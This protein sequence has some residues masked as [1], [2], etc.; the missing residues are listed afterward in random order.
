MKI[1]YIAQSYNKVKN[2]GVKPSTDFEDVLSSLG[3]KNIGLKR[4]YTPQRYISRMINAISTA[5]ALYVMPNKG[6]VFLQYPMQYN[7]EKL[8]KKA[9][10]NNNK[11]ILLVHDLNELRGKEYNYPSI[12]RE[13]DA[14]IVHTKPMRQLIMGKYQNPNCVVLGLF[15][16][17]TDSEP[18]FEEVKFDC[19]KKHIVFAG[20]LSKAPFLSKINLTGDKIIFDLYGVGWTESEKNGIQYHGSLSPE[21]LPFAMSKAHFGLIW[22]GESVNDCSGLMG[23]YLKYNC[24]YKTSSYL[25]AG[26]PLIAWRKMG[27]SSLIEDNGIGLIVD[28]LNDIPETFNNLSETEYLRMKDNVRKVQLKITSGGFYKEAIR[29]ALQLFNS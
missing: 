23:E 24:P 7:I 2:A 26:I 16:Y 4:L 11:I 14:L 10:S 27:I 15:D 25:S 20:N 3:I 17:I 12:L 8:F 28:S 19:K 1:S 13:A 9:K 29:E 18:I 22:D 5:K 6:I 21:K